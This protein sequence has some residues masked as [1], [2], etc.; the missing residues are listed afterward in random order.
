MLRSKSL[1]ESEKKKSWYHDSKFYGWWIETDL[2][3]WVHDFNW[4]FIRNPIYQIKRL[5]QWYVNVFRFDYDFDGHCL[6][7]IIEYKLKRI[8]KVLLNGH[9]IQEPQDMKALKLA[10]KLAGRLK[11]DNYDMV[12]YDRLK[13]KWGKSK[14]WFGEPDKNGSREFR[15]RYE[16]VK[17]KED[18]D[19]CRKDRFVLYKAADAKTKRE[20]KWLYSILHKYLRVW[21]D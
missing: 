16:K 20:E 5:Y 3:D 17:T 18:E 13:K 15:S 8:E 12:S 14:T 4:K 21:W 19:Q 7:A 2:S 10:I 11:D 9:A 6:F 1:K